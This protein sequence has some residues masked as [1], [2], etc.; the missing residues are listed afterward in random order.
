MFL[1]EERGATKIRPAFSLVVAF[2]FA[3]HDFSFDF[4]ASQRIRQFY[5]QRKYI[6]T[7]LWRDIFV[8][9]LQKYGLFI[10]MMPQSRAGIRFDFLLSHT[11]RQRLVATQTKNKH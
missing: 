11:L 6:R 10:F 4:L 9:S 3:T 8:F 2:I 7:T 5:R 1:G